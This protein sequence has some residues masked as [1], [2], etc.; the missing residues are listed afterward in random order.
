LRRSRSIFDILDFQHDLKDFW[1]I[2]IFLV[3]SH[4]ID[5]LDRISLD[6]FKFLIILLSCFLK[7]CLSLLTSVAFGSDQ[8]HS[9]LVDNRKSFDH[10]LH[11]QN[12]VLETHNHQVQRRKQLKVLPAVK[13]EL[14]IRPR[15]IVDD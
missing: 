7:T 3:L 10:I 11:V 15:G 9:F 13:F 2:E 4:L 8:N 6:L 14:L 12:G 1:G 5:L